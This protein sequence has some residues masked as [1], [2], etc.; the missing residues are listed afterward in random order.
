[1]NAESS[2][3][4]ILFMGSKRLQGFPSVRTR[5]TK[6]REVLL[7]EIDKRGI[8]IVTGKHLTN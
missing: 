5:R 3:I 1:M 6:L 4:G 7:S 2:V 8:A